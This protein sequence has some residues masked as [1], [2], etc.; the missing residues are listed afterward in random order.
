MRYCST[1]FEIR[2]RLKHSG[3]AGLTL[4]KRVFEEDF[5]YCTLQAFIFGHFINFINFINF[6]K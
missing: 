3:T 4:S 1:P 5:R 2:V 6:I